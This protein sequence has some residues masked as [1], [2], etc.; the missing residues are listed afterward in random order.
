MSTFSNTGIG[1]IATIYHS[2]DAS[3]FKE[4][5][6]RNRYLIKKRTNL[7]LVLFWLYNQFKSYK[8]VYDKFQKHN[9]FERRF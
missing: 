5:C 4:F 2:I 3:A 6:Q 7:Y 8:E 9:G 1:E